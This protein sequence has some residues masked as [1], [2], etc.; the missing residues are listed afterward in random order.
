MLIATIPSTKDTISFAHQWQCLTNTFWH[1]QF[2]GTTV[3]YWA[4]SILKNK[5]G[6]TTIYELLR[7]L[8][9]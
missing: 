8:V 9:K 4:K 3:T 7:M 1:W 2:S 5:T 6:L